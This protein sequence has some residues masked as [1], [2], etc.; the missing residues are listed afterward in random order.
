MAQ[1]GSSNEALT[2]CSTIRDWE[3]PRS[4]NDDDVEAVRT[5]EERPS[6]R[7]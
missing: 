3:H 7:W 1:T 2:G 5:L 4:I 6:M